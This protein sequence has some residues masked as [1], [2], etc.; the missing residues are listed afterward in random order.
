MVGSS[1][2]STVMHKGI[3]KGR[4]NNSGALFLTLLPSFYSDAPASSTASLGQ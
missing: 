4:L 1:T 2:T 3:E